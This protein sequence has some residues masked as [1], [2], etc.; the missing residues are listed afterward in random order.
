MAAAGAT[1][2]DVINCFRPTAGANAVGIEGLN[3]CG[4]ARVCLAAVAVISLAARLAAA[5]TVAL[6]AR[7]DSKPNRTFPFVYNGVSYTSCTTISND[8]R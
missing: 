5:A 8:G 4:A 2:V 1:T 7:A 6:A 3:Y